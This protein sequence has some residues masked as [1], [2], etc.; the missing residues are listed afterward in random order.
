M[1]VI[2]MAAAF[3]SGVLGSMGLGGGTVLVVYLIRYMGFSQTAAQ[4]INLFCFIPT[5]LGATV[6]YTKNKLTDRKT[7]IPLALWGLIGSAAGFLLIDRLPEE[8][9]QKLFG[10]FLVILGLKELFS[11]NNQ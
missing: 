6:I 4:G 11:K 7:V 3:L 5:A 8:I 9:L 2:S 10:G 1:N